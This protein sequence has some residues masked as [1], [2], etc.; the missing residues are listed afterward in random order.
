VNANI[1]FELAID[2]FRFSHELA[3]RRLPE[4]DREEKQGQAVLITPATTSV[5]P[6][7]MSMNVTAGIPLLR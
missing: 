3:P 2:T 5:L 1:R 7:G 4:D 6:P